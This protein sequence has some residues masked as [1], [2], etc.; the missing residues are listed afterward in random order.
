VRKLDLF[1]S[2]DREQLCL[3]DPTDY[4]LPTLSAEDGNGSSFRNVV[5]IRYWM[6]DKLQKLSCPECH[7]ASQDSVRTKFVVYPTDCIQNMAWND[8]CMSKI[9]FFCDVTPFILV[10]G[11]QHFGENYLS[12][13]TASYPGKSQC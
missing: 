6:I 8:E 7:T 1:P 11:Y 3:T 9:N 10:N 13:Y 12:I 5:S 4:V 2:G